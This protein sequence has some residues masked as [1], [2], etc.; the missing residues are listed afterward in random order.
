MCVRWR[1]RS[2][3]AVG[4]A[5]AEVSQSRLTKIEFSICNWL[6]FCGEGEV[7][8][9]AW[10]LQKGLIYVE[11]MNWWTRNVFTTYQCWTMCASSLAEL[12]AKPT[13]KGSWRKEDR[14]E[15]LWINSN[16][17][18]IYAVEIFKWSE[19]WMHFLGIRWIAVAHKLVA[20]LQS[21]SWNSHNLIRCSAL[22]AVKVK[23]SLGTDESEGLDENKRQK[24]KA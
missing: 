4:A 18:N 15:C 19:Y 6:H 23:Q 20:L 21:G 2:G 12:R 9:E 13:R 24:W 17:M 7:I 22:P 3:S 16:L 1:G 11:R 5:C 14:N 8:A 10:Q